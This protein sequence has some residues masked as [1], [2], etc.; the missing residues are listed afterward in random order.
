M[1]GSLNKILYV[2]DEPHI[3][4]LAVMVMEE[5]GGFDVRHCASGAEAILEYPRFSPELVLLDVMMPEMD[6]P[7]TL[8]RIRALPGGL[9]VPAVFMTAK[10]QTHEQHAYI[11]LGAV[12]IIP[13][14]FDPATLCDRLS[15]MWTAGASEGPAAGDSRA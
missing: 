11:A 10:A 3:A 6:G 15:E 4:E 1:P 12:G 2:E 9:S 5:F 13:K 14:P 7:E 8:Q